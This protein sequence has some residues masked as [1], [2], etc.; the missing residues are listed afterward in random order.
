MILDKAIG[1]TLN[2]ISHQRR[3]LTLLKSMR[4][5]E[6]IDKVKNDEYKIQM[7]NALFQ[8]GDVWSLKQ[9]LN[10]QID[11]ELG[12]LG[13]RELRRLAS[14][15]MIPYYYRKSKIELMQEINNA[16]GQNNPT[17]SDTK[18]PSTDERTDTSSGSRSKT[19]RESHEEIRAQE[20]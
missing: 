14:A 18:T 5:E 9:W 15:Y 6:I 4:T 2:N 11:Q 17:Q 10:K 19:I 16:R 8:A 12:E 7:F 1:D 20:T 13:V 3:M